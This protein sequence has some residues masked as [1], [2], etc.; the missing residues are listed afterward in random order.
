MAEIIRRAKTIHA[1]HIYTKKEGGNRVKEGV[2]GQVRWE[3]KR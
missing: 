2:V 3:I 1:M